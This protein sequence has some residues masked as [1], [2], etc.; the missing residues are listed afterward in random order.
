VFTRASASGPFG[1]EGHADFSPYWISRWQAT[2]GLWTAAADGVPVRRLA[3]GPGAL[4]PVWGSDGSLLFVRRDWLWLLPAGATGPMRVAG[5]LGALTG[6]AYQH[7]Y[8]GYAPYPQMIAWTR[9]RPLAT[10][11]SS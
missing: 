8:Y 9:A 10:A 1:P 5:P 3:A 2:G 7:T 4:D 11:G 6:S